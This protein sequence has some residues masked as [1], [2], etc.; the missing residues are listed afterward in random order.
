MN[1]FKEA[2]SVSKIRQQVDAAK[3]QQPRQIQL[4][5]LKNRHGNNYDAFFKYYSAHDYF[6]PCNE[7]DFAPSPFAQDETTQ[8]EG[9]GKE[10]NDNRED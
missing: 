5:C 2:V 8:G 6:L 4:K 3:K 10:G 9:K 7:S 1:H